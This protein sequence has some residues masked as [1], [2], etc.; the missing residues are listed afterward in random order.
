MYM[1]ATL[2]IFEEMKTTY[3]Q[4]VP[5]WKRRRKVLTT[6]LQKRIVRP[7]DSFVQK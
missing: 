1:S 6:C 2:F 7:L 3:T 5:S 4:H